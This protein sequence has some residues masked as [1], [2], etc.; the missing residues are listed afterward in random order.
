MSKQKKIGSIH[1]DSVDRK[2]GEI[3]AIAEAE[4]MAHEEILRRVLHQNAPQTAIDE[5]AKKTNGK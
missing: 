5:L 2:V 3:L 1:Q 4:K